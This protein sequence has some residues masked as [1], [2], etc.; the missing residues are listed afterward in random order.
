MQNNKENTEKALKGRFR[1]IRK[2]L[3]TCAEQHGARCN[4]QAIITD[5]GF[6][7]FLI[8]IKR[9][10][11]V[12]RKI[13]ESG[14]LA[15]SY[16]WGGVDQYEHT[17]DRT[18]FLLEERSLERIS[19]QLPI[20]ILDCVDMA[21]QL[22]GNYLWVDSLCIIQDDQAAKHIHI[23][24]MADIYSSAFLTIAVADALDANSRIACNHRYN[25]DAGQLLSHPQQNS[26]PLSSML[27]GKKMSPELGLFRKGFCPSGVFTP[28][29]I[30]SIF[31]AIPVSGEGEPRSWDGSRKLIPLRLNLSSL[32]RSKWQTLRSRLQY[33]TRKCPAKY[34]KVKDI[35][36]NLRGLSDFSTTNALY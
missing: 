10:C 31:G 26:D 12:K 28:Y 3:K 20:T 5:K 11:L 6:E 35:R 24:R 13:S 23:A 22:R 18:S 1:E 34:F 19:D 29:R 33:H 15:L 14:Y 7:V 32:L 25:I 8:D 9:M 16:V 17:R 36:G 2:Q 27:Q 4:A 21:R 30:K